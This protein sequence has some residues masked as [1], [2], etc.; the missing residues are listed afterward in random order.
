MHQGIEEKIYEI[1]LT[2]VVCS[3][4]RKLASSMN[5]HAIG[6]TRMNLYLGYTLTCDL[7]REKS[8]II[9][10]GHPPLLGLDVTKTLIIWNMPEV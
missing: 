2:H 8:F 4:C 6:D 1:P 5:A 10:G 3:K 7:C 9:Y